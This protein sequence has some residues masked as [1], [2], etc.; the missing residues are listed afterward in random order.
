MPG[1]AGISGRR[2]GSRFR[3]HAICMKTHSYWSPCHFTGPFG[4]DRLHPML[5]APT[6]ID[7]VLLFV[8]S[9]ARI[10]CIIPVRSETASTPL[11][12][13]EQWREKHG[14]DPARRD[15]M[16]SWPHMGRDVSQHLVNLPKLRPP[17]ADSLILRSPPAQA[18]ADD[19]RPAAK[20]AGLTLHKPS[21]LR[22]QVAGSLL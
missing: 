18:T 1:G 9:L 11:I 17:R 21:L 5:C 14:F 7:S 2:D 8:C 12:R 15:Q 13:D 10:D 3:A 22:L 16:F 6:L 19:E 20:L 4:R